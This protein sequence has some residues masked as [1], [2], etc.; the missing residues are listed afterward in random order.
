M[1]APEAR[2]L[3]QDLVFVDL[4][5]TGC[6]AAYHRITEIGIVRV[7][8]GAA[9]EEWSTLVNPECLIPAYV[10]NFTGITN[11]MV[12]AAPRFADIAHLVLEKLGAACAGAAPLF[13]AH[14]ARF[15]YSFLRAE[16]RRAGVPFSA[17]VLCTVKLSRRLFPEHVRHNLDAVMERHGLACTA[18]HRA[19]G[20][21]RV[22]SDFWLKLS[23]ELPG[24]RLA[25]AA[26][27]TLGRHKLPVYLPADLPDE[28]PEGPG[29]YR[30]YGAGDE[31]LYV[32]KSVSLRTGVLAHFAEDRTGS[33]EQK[34]RA[35]VRRVDWVETAGELG[36]LLREIECLRTLHPLYNRHLR[37]ASDGFTVRLDEAR[38]AA[39]ILSVAEVDPA[40]LTECFGLFHSAKD[41]RKA[42]IDIAAARVLCLKLFGLE[43]SDGS[44]FAYQS[45]KCR[46]ACA[47][48]ELPALHAV[49]VHMALAS[50]KLKAWPFPGR[51]A[52]CERDPMGGA[53]LHVFDRWTY[54]GSARSEEELHPL[55]ARDAPAAF[56][57]HVYR[58]LVRYLASH[59]KLDWHDLEARRHPRTRALGFDAIDVS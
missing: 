57:A 39:Q 24:P 22:I 43:A 12:A 20:D 49:R 30:L 45:G 11:Q 38:G 16:F 23:R 26:H 14:N 36:A 13:A 51:V 18:R 1:D 6:N 59:P 54:L 32:G 40:Q 17:K 42:L 19:L 28:L 27:S 50:L 52:L 41:A 58:V 29:I 53:D 2:E 4:E 15:D 44:C 55:A 48:K 37:A 46:G 8:G 5:T 25:A 10:E 3:P 34:L 33:R 35:Q 7:E 47:G 56:D 21:A 31:L 9:V